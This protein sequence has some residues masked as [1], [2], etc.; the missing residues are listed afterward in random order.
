[1]DINVSNWS[2]VSD[3]LENS[4]GGK[5]GDTTVDEIHAQRKT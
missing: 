1:M 3:F 5:V 2:V 4:K